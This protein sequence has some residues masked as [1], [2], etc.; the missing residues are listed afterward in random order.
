MCAGLCRHGSVPFLSSE[1]LLF[2]SSCCFSFRFK[3]FPAFIPQTGQRGSTTASAVSWASSS[4]WQ[5]E[6]V[7]DGSVAI[8]TPNK[9]ESACEV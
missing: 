2:Y 7:G 8:N 6:G 3:F 9:S 1:F 4:S 5:G